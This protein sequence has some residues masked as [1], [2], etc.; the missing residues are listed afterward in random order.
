[1]ARGRNFF[2]PTS[3]VEVTSG[4]QKWMVKGGVVN[5]KDDGSFAFNREVPILGPPAGQPLNVQTLPTAQVASTSESQNIITPPTD[6]LIKELMAYQR[7]MPSWKALQREA[8]GGT[9]ELAE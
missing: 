5:E 3:N 4:W 8:M 2:Q 6:D 7:T 1:M 9:A